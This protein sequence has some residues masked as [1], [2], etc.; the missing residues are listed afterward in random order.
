M[1]GRKRHIRALKHTMLL[2]LLLSGV[3]LVLSF[4]AYEWNQ[5]TEDSQRPAIS[6]EVR[7]YRPLVERYAEEDGVGNYTDV[8]L[9]I[10]MQESGGRGQDPMQASE[11]YCGERNCIED[12][13]LSIEQGVEYFSKTLDDAEGDI[14]LAVQSYNFG[15]GF[16]N[17]VQERSG[18]YSQETAI[19]F[20][21]YM[22]GR[23]PNKEKYRCLRDGSREL[24]ACYGDIYY[25]KAVMNYRDVIEAEAQ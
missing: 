23:D 24:D 2:F 7:E 3:L 13:E 17:Y 6:E 20:S 9:A 10:M 22:Y 14:H 11:S 21:Q 4:I 5:T 18:E 19:D 16:I 25:V 8:I 1:K 12:P 15:R